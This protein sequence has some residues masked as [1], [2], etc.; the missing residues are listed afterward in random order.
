MVDIT[1]QGDDEMCHKN[2]K[3]KNEMPIPNILMEETV[4]ASTD[5]TGLVQKPPS[6]EAEAESYE[7]LHNISLP[8][9]PDRK[10]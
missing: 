4:A 7:E 3:R 6:D 2:D 9:V 5:L 8:N 1:Y 10:R